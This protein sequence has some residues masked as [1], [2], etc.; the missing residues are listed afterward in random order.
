MD[1]ETKKYID[2]QIRVLREDV[3]KVTLGI[4]FNLEQIK[5]KNKF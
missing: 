3:Q 2:E 5:L 1:E 4:E